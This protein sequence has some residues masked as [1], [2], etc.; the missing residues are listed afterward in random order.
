MI[1]GEETTVF[2]FMM[3]SSHFNDFNNRFMYLIGSWR[4]YFGLLAGVRLKIG[5]DGVVYWV[6]E[7]IWQFHIDIFVVELTS[8]I[9]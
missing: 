3:L 6:G 4:M 9:V 7:M 8:T 1:S 2:S 5:L